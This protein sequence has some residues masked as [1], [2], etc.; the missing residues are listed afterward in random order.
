MRLNPALRSLALQSH[1]AEAN[2]ANALRSLQQSVTGWLSQPQQA[3]F[4]SNAFESGEPKKDA[5]DQPGVGQSEND[6]SQS[7]KTRPEGVDPKAADKMQD[8]DQEADSLE[9]LQAHDTA[10]SGVRNP[11]DGEPGHGGT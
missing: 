3:S 7:G 5:A 1:Y 11:A 6:K 8:D 10:D 4:S 2:S 9:Q